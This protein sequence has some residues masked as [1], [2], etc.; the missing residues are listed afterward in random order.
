MGVR[1]FPSQMPFC[2]RHAPIGPKTHQQCPFLVKSFTRVTSVGSPTG[3]A[4]KHGVKS[5]QKSAERCKPLA[6][7]PAEA[8]KSLSDKQTPRRAS[9]FGTFKSESS[10]PLNI[11]FYEGNL[12]AQ[13]SATPA[14]VAATP[15][16]GRCDTRIFRGCSATPVLHLQNAIKSRK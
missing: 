14:I 4:S 2:A 6:E 15:R 12:V 16:G 3:K 5:P 11:A 8:S 1:V 10:V 13:C 9:L 7:T